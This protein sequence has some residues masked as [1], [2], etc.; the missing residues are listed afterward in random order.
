[1]RIQLK[2][3][4]NENGFLCFFITTIIIICL[5][6][7]FLTFS[8]NN[9]CS[10]SCI[11]FVWYE[12]THTRTFNML[13]FIYSTYIFVK[14]SRWPFMLYTHG[15][16]DTVVWN[17]WTCKCIKHTVNGIVSFVCCFIS[18]E[19]KVRANYSVQCTNTRTLTSPA[20]F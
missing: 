5:L 2:W 16:W 6:L 7:L 18:V 20:A 10:K 9:E 3:N 14:Q 19:I 4:A 17:Y 8:Q 15:I 1:M 13:H 12:H 11:R